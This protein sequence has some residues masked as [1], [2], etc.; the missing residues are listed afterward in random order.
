MAS[1]AQTIE[2]SSPDDLA[3]AAKDLDAASIEKLKAAMM[4]AKSAKPKVL[5]VLG[6]PGV[7]KGTQCTKIVENFPEWGH[8][9][10][11]D[12]LR[13]ERQNPDSK[14]G[15][16]I[17]NYIKEGK[18]VPVAITVKLIQKAMTA[19]TGKT[20][21]LIDGFPRNKD[22]VTGWTENVGDGADIAGCLFYEATEEELEKRLLG[23]GEGRD[24]DNIETI[25]KRFKTYVGETQP[26]AELFKEKGQLISID[27]M[28]PIEDVWGRTKK[29]IQNIMAKPKVLFVLGGPGVG[30]GTQ[31][32]KIIEN[33]SDWGHISAGDCLRAERNNPDSKDGE[34]IN[35]YIK[36]GKI[37]PVAIT[38]KL[39]QKAMAN[40]SGKCC[41]LIDGFPRNADNVSGWN[42]NVGDSV[43]VAGCLFYEATEEELEK[44][45]LGRGQG[46][47]DD[48]IETI[49]KRFKT[50]V[51]ETKPVGDIFREKG[52]LI[53]I[54]GMKPI[55]EVWESTKK[56]IQ[57]VEAKR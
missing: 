15:E 56:V 52:Q 22:N 18:I 29:V 38:I 17:N 10:A 27:G 46:R 53:S 26:V 30:K 12:C 21:F 11:G 57:D 28:Q 9:S 5:F 42:E 51:A 13:A 24:D 41:F 35:N 54:D 45:L 14:D 37:V 50:Y 6:G 19:A 4:A 2:N 20:C 49:K 16:L 8:I 3:S 1:I 55:D 33:F 43:D 40:A 23:R 34:L 47:D 44:R 7:G 32:A 25:K 48:N 31:C 36:E 39:V